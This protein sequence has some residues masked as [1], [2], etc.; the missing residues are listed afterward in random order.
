MPSSHPYK[1]NEITEL[2]LVS[3]PK[4][5]LDVGSGFGKYGFLAREYLELWGQDET[6]HYSGEYGKWNRRIDAVEGFEKFVTPLQRKVYDHVYVGEATKTVPKLKTKYDLVLLIDIIEHLTEKQGRRL[7]KDS[8]RVGR[9]VIVVTPKDIGV[10]ED[11]FGNEFM[12]HRHQWRKRDFT[13]SG[14]HFFL[15]NDISIIAYVGPDADRVRQGSTI[16]NR[17]RLKIKRRLPFLVAPYQAA[18]RMLRRS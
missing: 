12:R 17:R 9:N 2:I 6:E 3:N 7:L 13:A 5:L 11:E 1:L 15:P 18:K 14:P 4:K 8:L 16:Y 10:Q